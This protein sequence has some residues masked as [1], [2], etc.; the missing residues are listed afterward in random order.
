M[1]EPATGEH[2]GQTGRQIA[3]SR[4]IRS[5]L[6]GLRLE[7]RLGADEGGTVGILAMNKGDQTRFRQLGFAAVANGNF[8]RTF[9]IDAAV[10][11]WECVCVGRSSTSLPDCT[12]WMRA[13][14]PYSL[15]ARLMLAAIA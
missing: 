11:R 1:R 2:I 10:I 14:H 12:P 13:H 3:R 6:I 8:R 5:V 7:Q 15:N 4:C 9:Q